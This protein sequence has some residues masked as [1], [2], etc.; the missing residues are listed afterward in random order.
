ML[1]GSDPLNI[2][3]GT[4]Y[5]LG[6][7]VNRVLGV[8]DGEAATRRSGVVDTI[9][10]GNFIDGY[11]SHWL[12]GECACVFAAPAALR[13]TAS[14]SSLRLPCRRHYLEVCLVG[15][16]LDGAGG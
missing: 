5:R 10:Q 14:R 8:A 9:K 6:A 2:T 16:L 13:G 12:A 11:D 7:V 3:R 4:Y 1:R 15:R